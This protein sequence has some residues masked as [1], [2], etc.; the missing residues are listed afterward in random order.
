MG[1]DNAGRTVI[2]LAVDDHILDALMSFGADEFEDQG[3][4]EPDADDEEDGS[5]VV[6]ELARPNVIR[7]RRA[8]APSFG[9]VG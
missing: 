8:V 6:V 1:R 5:P 2:P 9:Q 7:R 3:D 4:D